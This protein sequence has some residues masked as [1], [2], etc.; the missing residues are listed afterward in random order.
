MA[1]KVPRPPLSTGRGVQSH[2]PTLPPHS[3]AQP[4][5][6]DAVVSFSLRLA[7]QCLQNGADTCSSRP[8]VRICS[9]PPAPSARN[10]HPF[11]PRLYDFRAS[12]DS[13]RVGPRSP[14]RVFMV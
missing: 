10:L 12:L 1:Q 3:L 13:F 5:S 9:I 8:P 4:P 7:V 11:H 6:F 2:M 14:L